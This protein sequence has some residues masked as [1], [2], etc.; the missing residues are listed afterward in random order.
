MKTPSLSNIYNLFIILITALGTS[1]CVTHPELLYL[2]QGPEFPESPVPADRIPDLTIQPDDLIN[3]QVQA[4]DSEAAEPFNLE[5]GGNMRMNMGGGGMARP[6]IG[7]LVD[8]DGNIDFP[9]IG[10]LQ[11]TGLTTAELQDLITEGLRPYLIDPVVQVR[12]INFRIS[13]FGEVRSPGNYILPNERIT[14]LDALSGVGDLTPYANRTNVLVIREYDGERSY[15]R[16]NLQDRS[17]FE[18]PYFYL[19][20]NDIVYVEPMPEATAA[21]R[22]QA[23][24][25]LPWLSIITS[26]TTLTL[27]IVNFS[28]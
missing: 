9:G 10:T 11:V 19:K 25:I 7:Y 4:L 20:Q 5:Q 26:L 17:I 16:L 15:G 8:K 24:R 6:L 3:I 13:V 18:S 22:D 21:T 14:I 28:R 1:N 27:T 23:Q 2:S 12:F